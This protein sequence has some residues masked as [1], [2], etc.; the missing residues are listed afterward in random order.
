MLDNIKIGTRMLLGFGLVILLLAA[1]GICGLWGTREFGAV[2]KKVLSVEGNISEYASKAQANTLGMRR[3]EKDSIINIGAPEKQVSYQN[4]WLEEESQLVSDLARLRELAETADDRE[5]VKTMDANLK[6]YSAGFAEVSAGL[7]A[8][9]FKTPQEANAAINKYKEPIHKLEDTA[10]KLAVSAAKRM[11]NE[12]RTTEAFV[13]RVAAIII[14]LTIAALGAAIATSYFTTRRITRPLADG[15][16][17]TGMI[18]RG[19]LTASDLRIHSN[20]EVGFLASTL[21]AMKQSLSGMIG[22]II[23]T[24]GQVASASEELS[25]T[26]SQISARVEEQSAKA[27]QVATSAS[28]MSSTITEIAKNAANIAESARTTADVAKEGSGV[29]NK[30][31]SEVQAIAEMVTHSSR[32]IT[33]LGERSRQIGEI[34]VVINEIADQTNLLALNAAI[35]AARAGEHGRGFAVVADEVKKLAER[36]T[37][38]TKEIGA[39]IADIQHETTGAIK[40]MNE[41]LVRVETGVGLSSQAGKSLAKIVESVGA[42]QTMVEHIAA[43]TEEMSATSGEISDYIEV[44]ADISKETSTSSGHISAASDELSGLSIDLKLMAEKFKISGSNTA[45]VLSI[46][47]GRKNG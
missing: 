40:S 4:K 13:G 11:E 8:G 27:Q 43:S 5:A 33:S 44:I 38:S 26:V 17:M 30:T 14:V 6:A 25:A 35:E 12:E 2:L 23:T 29:V 19:D 20:D 24:S 36:T 47:G 45:R 18:A 34:V 21:N 39:M 37:V 31:V 15:V 3:F 9:T 28:Q 1:V 41:S 16:E 22:S 32:M 42:L 46:E 7:R 10:E